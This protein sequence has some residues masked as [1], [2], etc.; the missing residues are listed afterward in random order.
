VTLHCPGFNDKNDYDR[1]TPCDQDYLRKTARRTDAAQ[2]AAWYG[3][4]MPRI[5]ASRRM[6]D[7]DGIAAGGEGPQAGM[8]PGVPRDS[9]LAAERERPACA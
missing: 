8:R 1:E 5:L 2:L 4:Q 7:P 6:F 9:S 3:E